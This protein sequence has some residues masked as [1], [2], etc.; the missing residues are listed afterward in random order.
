MAS[1]ASRVRDSR[2]SLIPAAVAGG[3]LAVV[4]LLP[5]LS[6]IAAGQGPVEAW[7]GR[8]TAK[9]DPHRTDPSGTGFLPDARVQLLD[10]PRAGQEVEA[11]L[12]GPGGQQDSDAYRVGEDVVV[13]VTR[14]PA[15]S[16]FL[17]VADRW[18]LPQLAILVVVFV[19]GV[20]V[21]GG[22]RGARALLA[23]GLTIAIILK[24]FV[25]LLVVGVPPIPIAVVIATILTVLVIGLTEGFGRT[26]VA[27]ILGTSAAL[28]LTALL[29]AVAT[30]FAGFTNTQGS[31]L[32]YI[33]L[34]NGQGL[35]L[36]GLLTAAFMI[37]AIGVLDDVTV[38][39]AAAVDELGRSGLRDRALYR[40]AFN[41]GRS[42]IGATVNT[43]FLAYAGVSLPLL[44]YLI[45][46]NQPSSLLLNGE[47]VAIEIVRTLVGSLG[48]V[49][50]IPLTTLIAVWLAR[51][52]ATNDAADATLRAPSDRSL[53][54]ILIGGLAV[55]GI[56]TAGAT[57]LLG[58]LTAGS[59]RPP[60]PVD[61]LGAVPSSSAGAALTATP[62]PTA[63]GPAASGP[64]VPVF[65]V[66]DDVPLFDRS[67][68]EVGSVRVLTV[69]PVSA[70]SDGS[71]TVAVR[72]RYSATAPLTIDRG[73]WIAVGAD[74][75]TSPAAVP[76]D[77]TRHPALAGS[78]RPG[79]SKAGWLEF[80]LP[81]APS[82]LA[83][84]FRS[85][86]IPLFSIALF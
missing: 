47:P 19:A 39:Q 34:P 41:V 86:G 4:L 25:P 45:V 36:K 51:A 66:G 67:A 81:T 54:G 35:D 53:A 84:Q 17:A 7:H 60:L 49:A 78:L 61:Q 20:L 83:L 52:A 44:V 3:L 2:R 37:G 43:L 8:L 28:A 14:D 21:V 69:D 70:G 42:H 55:V 31:E 64:D 24:V 48:I 13:T 12:Q 76:A 56:V 85:L 9:L 62:S 29:A 1:V 27:A 10:G 72:F 82:G 15:G 23:L 18:R 77:V 65:A 75:Q 59:P 40:A 71:L 80:T 63:R 16:T 33:Q 6:P 26:A 79:Q 57:I 68:D 50:A 46:A 22:W 11:Y 38:T 30:A 58:P 5:P 32:A 74:G 73:E